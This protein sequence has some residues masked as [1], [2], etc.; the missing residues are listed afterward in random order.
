MLIG[1]RFGELSRRSKL[2]LLAAS[3]LF[4]F[5]LGLYFI[6][7]APASRLIQAWLLAIL[8]L[9]GYWLSFLAD[10]NQ[11]LARGQLL[12]A[13]AFG[14]LAWGLVLAMVLLYPQLIFGVGW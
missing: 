2:L 5:A 14:L 6:A 9:G 1:V 12:L 3:A 8:L 10:M 11:R 13:S 7:P 4:P